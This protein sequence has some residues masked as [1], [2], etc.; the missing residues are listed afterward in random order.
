VAAGFTFI[1]GMPLIPRNIEKNSIVN[2]Q[3]GFNHL[4]IKEE[5][6]MNIRIHRSSSRGH[7]NHGW[8]DSHHS[9]SFANYYNP[10]RMNF[11]LLRVLNDDVVAGGKG[12]GSHP[13]ENMEII[14]IPLA[15]EL[16]HRDNMGTVSVISKNDVQVMSA[17][18][19]VIHS[20][21]N[22]RT[23]EEVKFLQIWIFPEYKDIAP[24]YDQKTYDPKKRINAIQRI[25]SPISD[26]SDTVKINQ[27]A[28]LSLASPEA[29]T[30][31]TYK[32]NNPK[33]G[34]YLFN[35]QGEINVLNEILNTRDAMGVE[36]VEQV[37][38]T[39]KEDSELLLIEVPMH[40]SNG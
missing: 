29:G 36:E 25:V 2:K 35:L 9:F 7:A 37:T 24:R 32:L 40:L 18:T 14:S 26:S 38:I 17:G 8:L 27:R 31:L 28:Y 16:E 20:E 33:N 39:A 30:E 22:K 19:G 4:P 15:G 12:F 1:A 21:Y 13:H 6:K 3:V 10:E 11:G 5:N 23:D 34:L